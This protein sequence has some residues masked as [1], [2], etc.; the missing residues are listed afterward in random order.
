MVARVTRVRVRSHHP[1]KDTKE[2]ANQSTD[3][4][5]SMKERTKV[6]D[7]GMKEKIHRLRDSLVQTLDTITTDLDTMAKIHRLPDMLVQTQD[8]ITTDLDTM[9]KIL[10]SMDI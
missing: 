4:E 2:E 10:G 3:P 9:V 5:K 6:M 1:K 7:T 8:A